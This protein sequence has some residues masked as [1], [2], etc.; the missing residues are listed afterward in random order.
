MEEERHGG[1]R[2]TGESILLSEL[3]LRPTAERIEC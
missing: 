3:N 2:G 1:R